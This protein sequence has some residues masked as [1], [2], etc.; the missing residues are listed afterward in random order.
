DHLRTHTGALPLVSGG[1]SA[2]ARVACRTAQATGAVGVLCLAFPTRP[3]TPAGRPARPDRVDELTAVTVPTLVVQGD[4]DPYGLPPHGPSLQA[5]TVAGARPLRKA[6]TSLQT[7]VAPWLPTVLPLPLP[8][9]LP[10]ATAE[11]ADPGR[12]R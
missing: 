11:V 7:A 10:P 4:R 6:L 8:L 12:G 9:P 1:R 2:G 5:V 3:P